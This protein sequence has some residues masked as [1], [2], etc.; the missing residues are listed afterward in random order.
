MSRLFVSLLMVVALV[1]L[2]PTAG[3]GARPVYSVEGIT[4][5]ATGQHPDAGSLHCDVTVA[6]EYTATGHRAKNVMLIR[7]VTSTGVTIRNT[8][9]PVAVEP[10]G[11]TDFTHEFGTAH[12]GQVSW[13]AG[14]Y[15]KNVSNAIATRSSSEYTIV[16]DQCPTSGTVIAQ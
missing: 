11:T 12:A 10:D 16:V 15:G 3:L 8:V 13:S 5:T 2:A 9:G 6:V 4:V 7:S 14:L 1:A